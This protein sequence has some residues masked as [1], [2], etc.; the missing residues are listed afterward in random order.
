MMI[1]IPVAHIQ[2]DFVECIED[3][4]TSKLVEEKFFINV[5]ISLDEVKEYRV[6]IKDGGNNFVVTE[7]G[8]FEKVNGQPID[9]LYRAKLGDDSFQFFSPTRKYSQISDNKDVEIN[10]TT[11]DAI[12]FPENRYALGDAQGNIKIYDS[13]FNLEREIDNAHKQELTLTKFFPSGEVLLSGSTDMQLK[14]W[15]LKDGFNLRTLMG[16]T[17]KITSAAMIDRGRNIISSSTDG[18]LRLWECGSGTTIKKFFRKEKPTDPI[19]DISLIVNDDMEVEEGIENPLEFG[20]NGKQIVASHESGV[21]TV[22]D[23]FTKEQLLQF[24]SLYM[25]SCNSVTSNT[26]NKNYLYSGYQDGSVAQWDIRSS[27]RPVNE[28]SINHGI[29]INELYYYNNYLYVSSGN[30]TSLRLQVDSATGEIDGNLPTFLSNDD[31]FISQFVKKPNGIS[32]GV[33]AVGYREFCV[34]Y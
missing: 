26:N 10:W 18:T 30:D 5:D 24:P 3:I 6:N 9:T 7:R 13:K 1:S 19:Y 14:L 15:S 11:I 21:I 16:H 34:E 31:C 2:N 20:T 12:E 23:L 33:I 32:E 17:S 22:H 29:P 27:H 4:K 28:F 25:I 8:T